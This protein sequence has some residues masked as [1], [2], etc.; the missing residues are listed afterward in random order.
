MSYEPALF[1]ADSK[2]ILQARL[3]AIFNEEEVRSVLLS[4]TGIS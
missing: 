2:G 3:D 4:A 1:V